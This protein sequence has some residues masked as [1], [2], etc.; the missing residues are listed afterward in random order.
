MKYIK[1]NNKNEKTNSDHTAPK[2]DKANGF[3][4]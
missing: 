3:K 1:S 4:W 2:V